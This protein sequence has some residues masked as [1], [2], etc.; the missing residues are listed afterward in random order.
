M[1]NHFPKIQGGANQIAQPNVRPDLHFKVEKFFK[2]KFCFFKPKFQMKT[3]FSPS[4]IGKRMS[5]NAKRSYC[6]SEAGLSQKL[7]PAKNAKK[8]QSPKRDK[9]CYEFSKY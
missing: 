3:E 1:K 6:L 2:G 5:S 4:N 7:E 9:N 8:I